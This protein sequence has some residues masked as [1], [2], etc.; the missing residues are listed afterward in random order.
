MNFKDII[1]STIADNACEK[2]SRKIVLRLQ[3]M[4][5]EMQSGEDTP[6]KNLWDEV[7]VQVQGE[8]SWMWDLYLLMINRYIADEVNKLSD[9]L[10]QAIWIQTEEGL[11]WEWENKDEK[12]VDYFEK[13]IIRYIFDKFIITKAAD[14]TNK[15]IEEY[16]CGE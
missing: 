13:D 3:K 5:E 15:R 9:I 8:E 10:K 1:I 14:W 2:I 6:L 7:C 11:D 16:L 4:T 12:T